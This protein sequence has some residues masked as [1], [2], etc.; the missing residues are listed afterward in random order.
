MIVADTIPAFIVTAPLEFTNFSK[1]NGMQLTVGSIYVRQDNGAYCGQASINRGFSMQVCFNVSFSDDG[2]QSYTIN[3]KDHSV[4][5]P[6][7]KIRPFSM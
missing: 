4:V 1:L 2:S 6:G 5:I 3:G 7:N